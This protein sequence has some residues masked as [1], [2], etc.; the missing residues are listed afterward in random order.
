MPKMCQDFNFALKYPGEKA[1]VLSGYSTV[2]SLG[3]NFLLEP[4][5][6]YMY[7]YLCMCVCVCVSS[8]IFSG[9]GE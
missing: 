3:L 6:C 9:P 2:Y 5:F 7:M 8:N 4:R 1:G